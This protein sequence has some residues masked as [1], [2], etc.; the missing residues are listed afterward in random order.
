MRFTLNLRNNGRWFIILNLNITCTIINNFNIRISFFILFPTTI[1]SSLYI[2]IYL[3]INIT[4]YIS[5]LRILS[6][7]L[8][9]YISFFMLRSCINISFFVLRS[10]IN[11]CYML[12]RSS[13]HICYIL[14]RCCIH[15]SFFVLRSSINICYI[16][17]IVKV[18]W[19]RSSINISLIVIKISIWLTM[20]N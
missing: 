3:C 4:L 15:I 17:L 12:L 13:I 1:Y 9:I 18:I 8:R 19:L 6:N 10:S 14:L 2:F 11:I 7:R 16:L 5:G 20:P